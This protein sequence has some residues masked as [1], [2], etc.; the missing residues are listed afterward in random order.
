MIEDLGDFHPCTPPGG[1][2]YFA[3]DIRLECT[4][5]FLGYLTFLKSP[6][7]VYQDRLNTE[8]VVGSMLVQSLMR[9]ESQSRD[10]RAANDAP[11]VLHHCAFFFEAGEETRSVNRGE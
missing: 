6:L 4:E 1:K 8:S 2:E 3:S 5:F 9:P 11:N 10:I 7:H